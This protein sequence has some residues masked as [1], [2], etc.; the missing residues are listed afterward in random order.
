MLVVD[1]NATN[2]R[3]LAETLHLWGCR[4][5]LA[6]DAVAALEILSKAE[7]NHEPVSLILTDAQ[8]PD[9]DGFT[10]IEQIRSLPSLAQTV[11]MML[12]S[13]DHYASYNRCQAHLLQSA[14]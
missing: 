8:M 14:G 13:V 1:D 6:D 12:T 10:L 7:A 4:T 5:Q 3:I 2:R 9:V 11:V